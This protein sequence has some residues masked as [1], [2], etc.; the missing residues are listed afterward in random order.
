VPDSARRGP[1]PAGAYLAG[2][3]SSFRHAFAGLRYVL[4]EAN[5]RIQLGAFALVLIAAAVVGVSPSEWLAIVLVGLAVLLMEMLNTVV[6]AV[7]DLASPDYHPLARTAKDVAAGAVLLS[8][9]A[10]II[11]AA[12]IFVPR[13]VTAVHGLG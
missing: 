1:R 13:L 7:V 12:Y 10:A 3:V 8:A 9:F 4:G 6:E 2:R 5:F 11:V